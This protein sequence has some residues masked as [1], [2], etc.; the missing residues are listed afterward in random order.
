MLGLF[1]LRTFTTRSGKDSASLPNFLGS[2]LC[3]QASTAAYNS[4][5]FSYCL[6]PAQRRRAMIP[7]TFSK[8]QRRPLHDV[9]EVVSQKGANRLRRM[10]TPWRC[11]AGKRR[12]VV[13]S[14]LEA[15][16]EKDAALAVAGNSERSTFHPLSPSMHAA[17][18]PDQNITP[19]PPHRLDNRFGTSLGR[20]W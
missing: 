8:G 13:A 17:E 4:S 7:Q 2:M 11:L 16:A 14:L 9:G 6:F 20:S 3:Q 18:K 19:P 10:R 1:A 15:V 5:T 12:I